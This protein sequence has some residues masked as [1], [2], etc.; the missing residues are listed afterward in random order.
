[1]NQFVKGTFPDAKFTDV[2]LPSTSTLY[3]AAWLDLRAEPIVMRLPD[4]GDRFHV[5][6]V[7]EA[8][9]DVG[10]SDPCCLDGA[11]TAGAFCSL[12]SR[13]GTTPGNYAFVGPDWTDP[14]PAGIT[15]VIHLPTNLGWIIGRLLTSGTDD[16]VAVVE[17]L[18][19]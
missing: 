4:I 13:Y 10:G 14:L 1:V 3:C 17:G 18:F 6:Q 12:G 8:W 19:A 5:I 2:V 9:T 11:C 16:D 15:R 7:L